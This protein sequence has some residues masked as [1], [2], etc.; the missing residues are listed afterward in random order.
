M[1][2]YHPDSIEKFIV[3]G[4]KVS[5]QQQRKAFDKVEEIEYTTDFTLDYDILHLNFLGLLAVP[6]VFMSK[7]MGKKVVVHA[8]S[9]G[10]NLENTL[11]F[12]RIWGPIGKRYY[13]YIFRKSDQVIA[14]SDYSK[15][16]LEER[17]VG[18]VITLSNGVDDELL[19]GYGEIEPSEKYRNDEITV[20]NLAQLFEL[21]GIDTF[22]EVGESMPE[23]EFIWFGPRH[24]KLNPSETIKKLDGSPNNIHFPGFVDDKREAFAT[25]DIFL[26]PS[27][28]E[29]QGISVLE[30]SYCEMPI[31]VRDIEAFEGWLEHGE[32][33]LKAETT[34]EFEEYVKK[35]MG[36][37]DLRDKLSKNAREMAEKHTLKEIAKN[38]RNVYREVLAD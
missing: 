12:S 35:L 36:D 28:E 32:N 30:A 31:I 7:L 38:L 37:E 10:D 20:V 16:L 11:I 8:H 14:V 17:D 5:A 2:V 9:T 24:E 4:V 23:T 33:C 6:L 3:G 13:Q 1:K 18:D 27:R 21:K 29:T 19:Q 26:F 34:Q 22:L 15:E 25:G